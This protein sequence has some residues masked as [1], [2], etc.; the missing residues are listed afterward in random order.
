MKSIIFCFAAVASSFALVTGDVIADTDPESLGSAARGEQLFTEQCQACHNV[1][2]G[3]TPDVYGVVLPLYGVVDREAAQVV[4]FFYSK[5][6][7]ES[8]VI[9]TKSELVRYLRNPKEEIPGVRMEYAG[10]EGEQDRE[11]IVEFM[12]SRQAGD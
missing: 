9:W 4:G 5:A 6:M 12:N 11:D 2:K 1:M 7:R 8:G 10:L 3:A